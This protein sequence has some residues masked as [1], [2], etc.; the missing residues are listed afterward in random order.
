MT[1]AGWVAAAAV[2]L[3]AQIVAVDLIEP[4]PRRPRLRLAAVVVAV[5]LTAVAAGLLLG[6][7]A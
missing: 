3:W 7:E 2:A 1:G 6:G 5:A 4:G